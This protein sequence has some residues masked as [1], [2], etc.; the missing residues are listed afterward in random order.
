MSGNWME[1]ASRDAIPEDDVIGVVVAGRDIALY[2]VDGE[3]FATDNVCTHGNARLCDGFLDGHEIECPLH[4][5]KF[6]V[7]TGAALCA[8][9]T[10]AVKIYPIRIEAD[11]V[12][13]DLG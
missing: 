8:P 5:G 10:E 2:G 6:D 7:R 12:Y 9:L 13:V 11:K 3:V 4:Q 1:A